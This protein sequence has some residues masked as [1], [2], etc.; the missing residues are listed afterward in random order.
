MK[1][2]SLSGCQLGWETELR[3]VLV[4]S[5]TLT[6]WR[7]QPNDILRYPCIRSPDIAKSKFN[8]PIKHLFIEISGKQC[9]LWPLTLPLLPEANKGGLGATNTQFPSVSINQWYL[10]ATINYKIWGPVLDKQTFGSFSALIPIYLFPICPRS[11]K[12]IVF[13][14]QCE[15]RHLYPFVFEIS[16]WVWEL[17]SESL[18]ES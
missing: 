8:F 3:V 18:H 14:L 5:D 13:P 16:N 11:G 7:V 12:H 4:F 1:L 9:I 2:V 6:E 10:L 15:R 17:S